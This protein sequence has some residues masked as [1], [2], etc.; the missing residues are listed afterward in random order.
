[1]EIIENVNE[2]EEQDDI[3]ESIPIFKWGDKDDVLDSFFKDKNLDKK[4]I[5]LAN[6]KSTLSVILNKYGLNFKNN[7]VSASG[8][9]PSIHCPFKDHKEKTPS[10]GFNAEQN[11]FNCFGCHRAGGPI[12]FISYMDGR[13]QITIAKEVLKNLSSTEEI[14]DEIDDQHQEKII[15]ILADYGNFVKDW[16]SSYHEDIKAQEYIDSLSWSLDLYVRKYAMSDINISILEAII[17]KIVYQTGFFGEQ[18]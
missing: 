16:I 14:I 7:Q 8:W 9:L 3:R 17:D 2:P 11:I 1:M 10:F 6:E 4:I 12:Q 5:K 13:Q 15:Q 18:D